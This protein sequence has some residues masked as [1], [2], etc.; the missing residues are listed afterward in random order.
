MEVFPPDAAWASAYSPLGASTRLQW[1]LSGRPGGKSEEVDPASTSRTAQPVVEDRSERTAVARLLLR[2]LVNGTRDLRAYTT[3]STEFPELVTAES[4]NWAASAK[5]Q[6]T[7]RTG[8]DAAQNKA[9]S[10]AEQLVESGEYSEAALLLVGKS[11][12]T[13]STSTN[14]SN[15][16]A[17]NGAHFGYSIPTTTVPSSKLLALLL[18]LGRYEDV[19]RHQASTA[20]SSVDVSCA[21]GIAHLAT[22]RYKEAKQNFEKV[23]P[24][25]LK[26]CLENAS[27]TAADGTREA[28]ASTGD[29]ASRGDIALYLFLSC[30]ATSLEN[31]TTIATSSAALGDMSAAWGAAV[32]RELPEVSASL[33]CKNTASSSVD[34]EMTEAEADASSNM[35]ALGRSRS[36]TQVAEN[37]ASVLCRIGMRDPHIS[38]ILPSLL[39]SFQR[40]EL[41]HFVT[42]YSVVRLATLKPFAVYQDVE[43]ENNLL[44]VSRPPARQQQ[45]DEKQGDGTAKKGSQ[46]SQDAKDAELELLRDWATRPFGD[47]T[48]NVLASSESNLQEQLARVLHSMECSG[49]IDEEEGV[50]RRLEGEPTDNTKIAR[51]HRALHQLSNR[52]EFLLRQVEN[53]EKGRMLTAE[54]SSRKRAG[55]ASSAVETESLL[56]AGK[57]ETM[58]DVVF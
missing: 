54:T 8:T 5:E 19:A 7:T 39:Q 20:N 13:S 36:S 27:A 16:S 47:E 33:N 38:G 14:T 22:G 55:G 4:E 21:V 15:Y 41:I 35:E 34:V 49:R 42:P 1:L 57:Y 12:A 28:A 44:G 26:S 56:A 37:V 52:A 30:L 2:V 32:G 45:H 3:I 6:S 17:A 23:K 51:V 31:N 50:L 9:T 25:Q 18:W 24:E 29:I 48:T 10:T 11:S 53:P 40:K 43:L 58:E 46:Q